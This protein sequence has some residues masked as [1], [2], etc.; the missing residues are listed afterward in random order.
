MYNSSILFNFLNSRMNSIF[1]IM[2]FPKFNF[3]NLSKDKAKFGI[4]T[5]KFF[6]KL[7]SSKFLLFINST[8]D[9]NWLLAKF[10][11]LNFFRHAKFSINLILLL[12]KSRTSISG[13]HCKFLI[14]LFANF[15][16]L[17]FYFR[18]NLKKV[19]Y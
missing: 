18:I 10:K 8:N 14:L 7:M 16:F 17:K 9:V 2:F 11:I 3:L 1:D 13:K 6:R 15:Q 4:D 12:C 19:N 5:I